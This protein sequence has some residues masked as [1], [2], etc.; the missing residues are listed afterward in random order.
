MGD[1]GI[2][3]WKLNELNRFFKSK[4]DG[5]ERYLIEIRSKLDKSISYEALYDQTLAEYYIFSYLHGRTFLESK[6]VLL[7]E[8]NSMFDSPTI[9]FDVVDKERFLLSYRNL[10]KR[11]ISQINDSD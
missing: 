5:A 7:K 4:A 10:I 6:Q 3:E 11:L 2:M 8:L 1:F 9:A